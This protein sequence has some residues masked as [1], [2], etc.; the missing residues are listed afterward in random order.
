MDAAPYLAMIAEGMKAVRLQAVLVGNAAA[1]LRGAPVTTLDFD[2]TF[3]KT[4]TNLEKL[5][6]LAR[7][8]GAVILRRYYPASDL[9]RLVVEDSGLEIDFM[10]T[11]HGVRSFEALRSRAEPFNFGGEQLLVA[12]L[13][14]VIAS[15]KAQGK[16]RDLAVLGI[17]GKTAAKSRP[18]NGLRVMRRRPTRRR[19]L[20]KSKTGRRKRLKA[21]EAEA[22]RAELG[23]SARRH[24][25]QTDRMSLTARA[26]SPQTAQVPT[27]R[28]LAHKEG[29]AGAGCAGSWRR[30]QDSNPRGA[31]APNGFQN[32][33]L[34]P[35]GQ[36]A[37]EA[38]YWQTSSRTCSAT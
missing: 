9:Y 19:R 21:L 8:L 16:P 15:K 18:D 11:L 28:P 1:A 12:S 2:F 7:R 10:T 35:L 29:T 20:L 3:R 38:R 30:V 5:K 25:T 36:P 23:L 26:L 24:S 14:D 17:L 33:R 37:A 34:R 27:A 31:F 22:E 4:R 13:D 6:R 32:R